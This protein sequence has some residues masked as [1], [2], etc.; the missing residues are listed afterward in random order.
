MSKDH[1]QIVVHQRLFIRCQPCP[2]P[3]LHD[4]FGVIPH[5]QS[6]H[7]AGPTGRAGPNIPPVRLQASAPFD[8]GRDSAAGGEPN[9]ILPGNRIA[10]WR[11]GDLE[12]HVGERWHR[13][14]ADDPARLRSTDLPPENWSSPIIS[15]GHRWAAPHRWSR[16]RGVGH[17][18]TFITLCCA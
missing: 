2:L 15:S 11:Q 7:S 3:A 9:R 17:T 8:P 5:L 18:P 6:H 13:C 14:R 12:G 1:L 16:F 4:G 10:L